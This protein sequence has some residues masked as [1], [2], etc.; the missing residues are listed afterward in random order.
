MAGVVMGWAQGWKIVAMVLALPSVRKGS[1]SFSEK[2]FPF[3]T[4]GNYESIVS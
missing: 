3:V 1:G 2:I 4:R